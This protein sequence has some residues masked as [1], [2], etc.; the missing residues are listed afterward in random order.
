MYLKTGETLKQPSQP[1]QWTESN[2]L[3]SKLALPPHPA[4]SFI[5]NLMFFHYNILIHVCMCVYVCVCMCVCMCVCVCV[6]VFVY[7]HSSWRF[8][9][10]G[11]VGISGNSL[12]VLCWRRFF[13]MPSLFIATLEW[14]TKKFLTSQLILFAQ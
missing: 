7:V 11:S 14:I 9:L 10:S 13:P 5:K 8:H 3:P 12:T 2:D 6:C 4:S 1:N